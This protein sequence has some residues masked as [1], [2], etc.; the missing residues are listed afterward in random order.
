V[1]LLLWAVFAGRLLV[2]AHPVAQPDA[3]VSLASHEWER[4][5]ATAAAASRFPSARV[6][7][8]LPTAVSVNNCHDCSNRVHRLMV[9]GVDASRVQVLPL[10]LEGTRGEA[11]AC[12]GFALAH[13]VTRLLVITSPYHTRRSLAVFLKG[14]AGT[15]VQIGVEPASS[16]SPAR[17]GLWWAAGYDLA[18][19]AYEWAAL[20]YYGFAYDT[21]PDWGLRAQQT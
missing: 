1:L 11:A 7:L 21:W 20:V 2:L 16:Y 15:G 8:T 17:P 3:I 19:V 4:L 12:R 6:L 13:R 9:M 5:P 10:T 14:F 18:Y